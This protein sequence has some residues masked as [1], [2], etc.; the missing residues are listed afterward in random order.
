MID[1]IYIV[2]PVGGGKS[3]LAR[4]LAE[5]YGFICCELDSVD[6]EPDAT[7]PSGNRKR[8]E[9]MRDMM[10]GVMLSRERWI[11]EDAGRAYFEKALQL[12]D[13]VILLEPPIFVRRFR[14]LVR[15]VKQ[16]L[17]LEKCGYIPDRE[18]LRLMFKW[19][20]NYDFGVDGLKERLVP[21]SNNM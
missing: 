16:N 21:Y 9:D 12:A 18:M 5:K 8:P 3:T 11:V 14:I 13:S 15:W 6:Y 1:K 17:R 7:S 4:R 19:T 10:L 2:G 20:R